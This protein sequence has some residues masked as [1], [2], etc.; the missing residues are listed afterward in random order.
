MNYE[1]RIMGKIKLTTSIVLLVILASYF[2]IH[3]STQRA[4]EIQ[5]TFTVINPTIEK[6][7]DPGSYNEGTTRVINETNVPL[8]FS[9]SVQDYTV[10]DNNGTPQ[11]LAPN[12]LNSKYSG[13]AWIGITPN[14]FTIQPGHSQTLNY[15]IQVPKDAKPGGHYAAIIYQPLVTKTQ[16][17][18]GGVVNTQIGSLFY[19]TI[20]G[21]ITEKANVSR[22]F[23]N[24]FS[25][26]GPVKVTT[27]IK[28][29]GDLH[30]TPKATITV[31]GLFFKETQDL[32][33]H[34]IFPETARNFENTFGKM[35]MIGRYKAEL[36]GSY[37]QDKNLPLVATTYFWVFPWRIAVV[38]IL[39]AIALILGGQYYKKKKKKAPKTTEEPKKDEEK[40]ATTE[41]QNPETA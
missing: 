7:L 20:K 31:S 24:N 12:V 22:L 6:K 34:N 35:L 38:I 27:E 19:V 14:S 29:M 23:A 33:T 21:P 5:R 32:D 41:S 4:Q 36:I 17:A 10:S 28:N 26:Y 37:G 40:V 11:I 3:A 25:E 13:A 2:M 16:N 8:S 18:T 15:F 1:L 9:V 30:I 39:I